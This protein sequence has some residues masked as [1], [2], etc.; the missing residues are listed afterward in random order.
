MHSSVSSM[1]EHR[2]PARALAHENSLKESILNGS[3]R[4]GEDSDRTAEATE[5]QRSPASSAQKVSI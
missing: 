2:R 5:R 4:T 1:I 3:L